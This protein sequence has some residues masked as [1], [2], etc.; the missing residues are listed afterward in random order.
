MEISSIH[1]P[2]FRI[3]DLITKFSSCLPNEYNILKENEANNFVASELKNI[4]TDPEI[5]EQLENDCSLENLY[6][7]GEFATLEGILKII[8]S[9]KGDERELKT[10]THLLKETEGLSSRTSILTATQRIPRPF[11]DMSYRNSVEESTEATE[12]NQDIFVTVL[13][14]RPFCLPN[15]DPCIQSRQLVI[16]Q[17]LVLLSKQNLTVLRDAIKCPQDKVWL[18]DCSEALDVPELHVSAD[19]LY[20]SSYFFIEGKFYDDLRNANS[21]SLGQEVIQWAKSKRELVSCGPFTS[22]P[23][24]SIT[25]EN[26]AVCIGKPYFFVH[27]G[28]CE[29]MIIFSDIR[30]VDRDSCQSESSFPMLTGRCS[31]RILHCF[32]C[33]RLAC[34]W[35]VTECRTILPVDPCPICDVCIR[36]L[37]YTADGKKIDPHFRVLMYCGEEIV[38]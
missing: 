5:F 16:T 4:I 10:L 19:K 38:M 34:R 20:T 22:S 27:Q 8:P 35:I 32:A 2:K 29:H 12:V 3:G 24:E 1:S 36:L 18:G 25:L 21:K 14:Y 15:M 17:R 31:A 30:L 26:L 9:R 37:L 11:I 13:V 23:M 7:D 33:R 28:N 6:F